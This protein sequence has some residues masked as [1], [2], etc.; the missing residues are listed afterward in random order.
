MTTIT[1]G[2]ENREDAA[3]ACREV[4]ELIEQGYNGGLIG[5]STDSWNIED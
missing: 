3:Q 4:A 2:V 1:I 5:W